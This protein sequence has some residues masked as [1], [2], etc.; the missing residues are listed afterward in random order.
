LCGGCS[1]TFEQ[2]ELQKLIE[3][4]I[5]LLRRYGNDPG[6]LEA[7]SSELWAM[8]QR[9][10][11]YSGII[12]S[13]LPAVVKPVELGQLKEGSEITVIL[14]DNRAV[15]GKVAQITPEGI[16][17]VECRQFERPKWCEELTLPA[18]EVR[19]VRLLTRGI[20]DK[21]RPTWEIRK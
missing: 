12:A 10:S 18:S 17:L 3:E 14:R 15:A 21:E 5:E 16:K 11:I 4:I 6:A 1:T 2:S 13:L 20:L 9:V 19:E 7:I 8:Y